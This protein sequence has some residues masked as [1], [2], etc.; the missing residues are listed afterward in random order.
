M[1]DSEKQGDG[2]V[3]PGPGPWGRL[4]RVAVAAASFWLV[5]W[6]M[7]RVAAPPGGPVIGGKLE[8]WHQH[9]H[10]YD[11]VFVGSSHVFRAFVPE[12]FDRLM[13]AANYESRSFN[14]GVQAVSLIEAR[15]LLEEVLE[16]GEGSLRRVFFEYQW[17]TPQ[18][19]PANAFAPRTIYWHDGEATRLAVQRSLYWGEQL[20]PDFGY[21]EDESARHGLFSVL[22]RRLPADLRA[23]GGHVQHYLANELLLGRGK[24][25]L[26]GMSGRQHG[27]TQRYDAG[28]GY[29][30]LEEEQ[31]Q[32]GEHGSYLQRRQRFLA[33]QDGYRQAVADL[34]QDERAFG[35]AEWLNPDL[36][37]VNDL[38]LMRDIARL[39]Q[40]RG[41]QFVLVLMP[42][43]S[44]DR[45]FED[46]LERS[47]GAPLL[48]YNLPDRYPELYTLESRFDSGHLTAAGALLFT[49]HLAEDYP[50]TLMCPPHEEED[51]E[52]A[53]EEVQ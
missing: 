46:R 4:A 47:L 3:T 30:S 32:Q 21:A 26:K 20:G 40:S 17:L 22:A 28:D 2:A 16:A 29:L 53:Q 50:L 23:A 38:E 44:C 13:G 24:D 31:A 15:H 18:I 11:T 52:H 33:E 27:Q 35:D 5:S 14:F 1:S 43:L 45:P 19:D 8:F 49:R 10:E 25:V 51:G 36:L 39:A 48:R 37:R 34:E 12:E 6:A 41:V 42:S 9:A 7:G